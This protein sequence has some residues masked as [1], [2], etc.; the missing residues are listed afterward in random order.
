M[1]SASVDAVI[2]GIAAGSAPGAACTPDLL[3]DPWVIDARSPSYG[4]GA[5]MGDLIPTGSPRPGQLPDKYR[6]ADLAQLN[7]RIEAAKRQLG[8]R[9]VILGHFYQRDEVIRHADYVG[10]S[11]QL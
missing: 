9:V 5:S 8:E 2:R 3:S 6:D 11:F 7:R 1:T 10:D 4:P